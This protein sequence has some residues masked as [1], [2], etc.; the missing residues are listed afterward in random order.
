MLKNATPPM[1]SAKLTAFGAVFGDSDR[2]CAQIHAAQQCLTRNIGAFGLRT[3]QIRPPLKLQRT[4]FA[5]RPSLTNPS[6]T[7]PFLTRSL[8]T[9]CINNLSAATAC[10]LYRFTEGKSL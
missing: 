2:L 7:R 4:A 6:L 1:M 9:T 8:V 3:A 10:A 5:A